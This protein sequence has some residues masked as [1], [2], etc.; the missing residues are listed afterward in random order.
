MGGVKFLMYPRFMQV[1]LDKQVEGMSKHK[2]VYVTPSHTKKVFA[3][4]KRPSKGF[5]GR[6]TPLFQTMMVQALKD[7][8][9]VTDEATTKAHVSTPSYDP[10][11]SAKEITSLKKRVKQLEKRRKLRSKEVRTLGAKEGEGCNPK[12]GG[13]GNLLNLDADAERLR[14]RIL[15]DMT[16]LNLINIKSTKPKAITTDDITVT[17]VGKR[18]RQAK[19]VEPEKP[20]KFK[21]KDQISLDEELARKLEAEIGGKDEKAYG[22]SQDKEVQIDVMPLATKPPVI[23]EYKIV[24]EGRIGYFQLIRADGS[25]KRSKG[26]TVADSIA[27]RLTRPTAYKFKTD[28]SIIPVWHNIVVGHGVGALGSVF[29]FLVQRVIDMVMAFIQGSW[30]ID[31]VLCHVAWRRLRKRGR[32]R[33]R[34]TFGTVKWKAEKWNERAFSCLFVLENGIG[35][36]IL[37]LIPFSAFS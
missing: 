21:G 1:F 19:M 20:V 22:G 34:G 10:H 23:V 28:C 17:H 29:G 37:I 15:D 36:S 25:S 7:M 13:I 32:G 4:M 26:R 2:E 5:S 3:N 6:I 30:F 18:Q 31:V 35:E 33:K 9:P 16:L 14:P 27:E 12:K 8:E 11:P 24:K